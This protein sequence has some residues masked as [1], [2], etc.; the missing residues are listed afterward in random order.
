M[1][2]LKKEKAK[3]LRERPSVLLWFEVAMRPSMNR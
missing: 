1:R 3:V 2:T